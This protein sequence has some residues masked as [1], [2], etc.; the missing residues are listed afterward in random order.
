MKKVLVLFLLLI[1]ILKSIT[2]NQGIPKKIRHNPD[3]FEAQLEIEINIEC[4]KTNYYET[5]RCINFF[6]KIL[7]ETDPNLKKFNLEILSESEFSSISKVANFVKAIATWKAN[8]FLKLFLILLQGKVV[9]LPDDKI[10]ILKFNNTIWSPTYCEIL[11]FEEQLCEYIH[12]KIIYPKKYISSI[13]WKFEMTKIIIEAYTELRSN[14]NYQMPEL[15]TDDHEIFRQDLNSALN[16]IIIWDEPKPKT[17]NS[18]DKGLNVENETFENEDN[19]EN[20]LKL[21]KNPFLICKHLFFEECCR[22]C[23]YGL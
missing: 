19:S 23:L 12:K 18:Q 11:L 2:S 1:P 13:N 15:R 14:S 17:S 9:R 10:C 8:L 5:S 4:G 7:E 3:W 16:G 21:L 22:R 20:N 6:S